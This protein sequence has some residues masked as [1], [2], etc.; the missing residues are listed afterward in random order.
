MSSLESHNGQHARRNALRDDRAGHP[1]P[2]RRERRALLGSLNFCPTG[3]I[4]EIPRTNRKSPP[5]P[6]QMPHTTA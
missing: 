1:L 3:Q 4:T 5:Q 6:T 2:A